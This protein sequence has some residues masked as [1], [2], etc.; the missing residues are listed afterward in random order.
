[1]SEPVTAPITA[2]NND[3]D[4]QATSAQGLAVKKLLNEHG[5]T[6]SNITATGKS[7]RLLKEDVLAHIAQTTAK[8]DSTASTSN[9]TTSTAPTISAASVETPASSDARQTQREPISRMRQ[10]IARRLVNAQQTTAML[11]TFNEVDMSEVMNL[12]SKYKEEFE[13]THDSKLGFMAFFV[14]ASTAALQR[15]PLINAHIDGTDIIK[16]SYNDIGIAV[17]SPRGLVVPIVRDAETKS[18]AE[19]ETGIRNFGKSAF[20]GSLK[21]DDL[22]GGTFTITNGGV[23]GSLLSTPIL[24][25]P[26][27]AILGMHAIQQRPMAVNGE[28]VIRPMMYLALSY[29]HRIVDG[30]EAVQFLVSIKNSVEDPTR[31]LLD[32]K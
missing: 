23:F 17:S 8:Q 26:Q 16:A 29:D 7:G 22:I 12:R 6:A 1:T 13:Q 25:P 5:L 10:T 2:S 32:L 19:I 11:T 18:F 3:A 24:N 27:S 15:F 20:E 28:V 4:D 14:K 9:A 30:K 21:M 31:L